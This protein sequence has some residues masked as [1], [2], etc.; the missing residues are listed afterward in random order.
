MAKFLPEKFLKTDAQLRTIENS[1]KP[2]G[3]QLESAAQLP[4]SFMSLFD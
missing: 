2:S 3:K 1:R 4:G